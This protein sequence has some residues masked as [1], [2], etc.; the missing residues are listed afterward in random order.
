M[1]RM[2][3]IRR[4]LAASLLA[5]ATAA[6]AQPIAPVW[7]QAEW[8]RATPEAMG[9]DAAALALLVEYGGN[10]QMDSL[11][12]TRHGRL[13][14]EAYYA[15]FQRD[16]KHRINSA[17]KAVVGTLAGIAM[18]EGRMKGPATPL[19][20][21][22]PDRRIAAL[23]E[24]KK[25]ITLQT[26][27]DNTA[28]LEWNEPLTDAPPQS[29]I[30]MGRTRD[31]TQFVLDRPMAT[32]PGASF[33]YSSGS[34]HVLSAIIG[35]TTGMPTQ[36]YADEKLFKPLG[37][38][39]W[40]WREDP[41]G[42]ATG[43]WG[44]YLRTLDMARIGHLYAQRGNWDGRQVVPREWVERVFHGQVEMFPGRAWRYADYWWT[45]PERKA[46]LAVGFLR[47]LIVVMPE[48]GV[49]AAVTGRSHY[50]IENLIDHL[51][52]AA[53]SP[54]PLPPNAEANARLADKVRAA[55]TETPS[56]APPA[57]AIA[58]QISGKTYAFSRA[59]WG[60][61]SFRLQLGTVPARIEIERG[62][63][64]SMHLPIGMDGRFAFGPSPEGLT[65]LKA[66]WQDED[67]LQIIA[68]VPEEAI[69]TTYVLKFR[70]TQVD[71]TESALLT[72]RRSATAELR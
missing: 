14:L 59:P 52:R 8:E 69:V 48:A 42:I 33:N 45:L 2:K 7:P 34:P 60:W 4:S 10:V 66:R 40:R 27:L 41:Q 57:P 70:G 58:Q 47:Q 39:D 72:P 6:F 71:V 16:M 5:L 55:A 32:A 17:T 11:V 37:I 53:A 61:R 26:V 46:Y 50:P 9:M 54:T 19:I 20:D 25:A 1:R 18:A 21:F 43:G 67:T 38:A 28:G 29:A 31:W 35:R 15:P 64:K 22:F 56:A 51:A 36:Q 3:L 63:G 44:L 23:D 62:D 30:E 49:V 68:R 65:G 12:V 13:V 24:R